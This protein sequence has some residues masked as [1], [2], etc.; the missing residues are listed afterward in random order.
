MSSEPEVKRARLTSLPD[1]E[2]LS[3]G[4]KAKR[5][6]VKEF[7][8]GCDAGLKL[9]LDSSRLRRLPNNL[10]VVWLMLKFGVETIYRLCSYERLL[11]DSLTECQHLEFLS[12]WL[13]LPKEVV[14]SLREFIGEAAPNLKEIFTPV[15]HAGNTKLI[16]CTLNK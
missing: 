5:Q 16:D 7:K 6:H 10:I 12:E 9:D 3:S 8:L 11:P 1:M 4:V 15:G 13:S 14:K 2:E